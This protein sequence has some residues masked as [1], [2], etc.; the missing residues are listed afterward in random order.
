M[1]TSVKNIKYIQSYV[2][3]IKQ[4]PWVNNN[5]H[6]EQKAAWNI[7]PLGKGAD[8]DK[9]GFKAN[10]SYY[11]NKPAQGAILSDATTLNMVKHN[12][13]NIKLLLF[14]NYKNYNNYFI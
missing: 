11:H 1:S 8:L 4:R 7:L 13:N 2:H 6:K 9:Q 10:S 12:Y 3:K 14:N 5:Y